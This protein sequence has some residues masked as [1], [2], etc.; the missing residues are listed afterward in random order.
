MHKTS[1]VKNI[2][3]WL[4]ILLIAS[5]ATVLIICEVGNRQSVADNRDA[6][7]F[8]EGLLPPRTAGI[9]EERS[10]PELSAVEYCGQDYAALI[11]IPCFSVKLPVCS[12]WD[13]SIVNRVPC[14]FTG[15]PY[16]G[17]LIIGGVDREGQ[18]DFISEID[19]GDE[20]NVTD[21][22]GEVFRYEV[23]IVKHSKSAK[24]SVLEDENYDLT[25]FAKDSGTG[26]YII[27]RC[28]MK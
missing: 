2:L 23:T 16:E 3:L 27:V 4:G 8:I 21:M 17:S 20:I 18:F 14:R 9:K 24:L 15:N 6:V 11:E 1:V 13:K 25:L 12:Q 19:I 22:Q 28:N 7:V 26:D 10:N 5:S